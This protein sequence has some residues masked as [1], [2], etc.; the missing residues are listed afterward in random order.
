VALINTKTPEE[1]LGIDRL[2]DLTSV[3]PHWHSGFDK[4]GR[5]VLYKQYGLFETSTLLKMTSIDAIMNYHIWEQEVIRP[6]L[7]Y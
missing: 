7:Y 4:Y 3:F 1:L 6:S 2:S 5:P